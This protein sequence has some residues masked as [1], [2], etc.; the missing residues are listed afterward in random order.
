MKI[1]VK[2][3]SNNFNDLALP[4]RQTDGA[5]GM[6]LYAA[7]QENISIKAGEVSLISTGIA[8]AVPNNYECQIRS[9]SGLS[10]KQG[11]FCLNSPGTVDSDYRGEIKVILANF[12]K[13]T[14]VIKRGDRIAQ[15]VIARFEKAEL[16]EVEHLEETERGAAGFGSTGSGN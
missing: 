10:L 11:L 8:I 6:D 14:Q 13:E 9:R 3:I 1:Q 2:R 5:S 15:M 4:F 12:S 7:I 16:V